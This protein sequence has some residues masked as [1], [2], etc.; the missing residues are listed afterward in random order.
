MYGEHSGLTEFIS[1]SCK[2]LL[3]V[4]SCNKKSLM[5]N[6][7]KHWCFSK[8]DLETMFNASL[9]NKTNISNIIV[10]NDESQQKHTHMYEYKTDYNCQLFT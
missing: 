9:T 8:S 5:F 2:K 10:T 1:S 3:V 6:C 4:Y 7:S